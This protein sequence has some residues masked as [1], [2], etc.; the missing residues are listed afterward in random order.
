MLEC[1]VSEYRKP[2][3]PEHSFRVFYT[4]QERPKKGLEM[5]RNLR[6]ELRL[7]DG[8]RAPV[9]LQHES[10]TPDGKIAGVL[11]VVGEWI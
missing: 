8:R 2:G 4:Y 1:Q 11:R 10:V 9:V 3:D 6:L 5:Y 7:D